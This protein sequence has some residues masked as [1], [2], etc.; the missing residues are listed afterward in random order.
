MVRP[1]STQTVRPEGKNDPNAGLSSLLCITGMACGV[2]W[3]IGAATLARA[4]TAQEALK[5]KLML[6]IGLPLA[7]MSGF[8][9]NKLMTGAFFKAPS[10]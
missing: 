2:L 5:G 9:C 4:Q 8:G 6:G 7:M 3:M 10:W 1:V